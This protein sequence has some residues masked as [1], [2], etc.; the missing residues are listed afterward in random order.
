ME[1]RFPLTTCDSL[2]KAM[3]DHNSE[4]LKADLDPVDDKPVVIILGC[5]YVLFLRVICY[6]LLCTLIMYFIICSM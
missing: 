2:V 1:N 3:R 5:C 4:F 6:V